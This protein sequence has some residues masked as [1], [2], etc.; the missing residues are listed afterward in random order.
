MAQAHSAAVTVGGEEFQRQIQTLL[1][2]GYPEACG[3]AAVDF[4]A[5]VH[6]LGQRI[7]ELP[8]P[9]T[10]A[11]GRV[12]FVVVVK[13]NLI[14]RERAISLLGSA[15]KIGF[16]TMEHEDLEAF[17]P[18]DE[19]ETPSGMAYLLVDV[20]TGVETLNVTPD[21]AL[22]SIKQQDR[23]PL[24]VDEGIA[25]L[26]HYPELLR[27]N[28]GF[29]ML[30]SRRADRRVTAFWISAGRPRLGWCWAGNPHSWLGSASCARR[31]GGVG[32][33]D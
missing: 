18:T 23:S 20:D 32:P 9:G 17:E 10:S 30:G 5:H 22:K 19:E 33:G 25:L 28:H 27:K 29:S 14:A 12:P 11:Q 26:T 15:G 4:L 7:G 31:V 13:N 16:T 21:E 6:P 2:K 1:R 8:L 24:T 3:I